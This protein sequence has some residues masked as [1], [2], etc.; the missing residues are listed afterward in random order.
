MGFVGAII[1]ALIF[2]LI[3]V[4]TFGIS[5]FIADKLTPVDLWRGLIEE[6]NIALAI[7]TGAVA[8]SIGMIV[9]SAVHG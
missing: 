7:V 3:G 5:F 4:I 6:K 8:V 1:N 2:S 9:A